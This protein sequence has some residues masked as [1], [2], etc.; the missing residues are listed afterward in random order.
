M[1]ENKPF[2]PLECGFE[3]I[4]KYSFTK[5]MDYKKFGKCKIVLS[6]NDK[7]KYGVYIYTCPDNHN[8]TYFVIRIPNHRFGTDLL[9]NLGVIE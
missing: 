9:R 1:N 5:Y 2:N 8:I 3:R 4:I 7:D 6:S